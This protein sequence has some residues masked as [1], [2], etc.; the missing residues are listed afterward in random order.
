LIFSV[1]PSNTAA[2]TAIAPPVVVT[3]VDAFNNVATGYVGTI[4]VAMG[5]N[6]GGAG[7]V[8]SGTKVHAAVAG[9]ATF[10]DLSINNVGTGY[11]LTAVGTSPALPLIGSS[12]FNIN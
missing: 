3:A 6:A 2:N 5:T 12:A 9:V 10:N 4:T 7:T 11:T 1:Q 8:L